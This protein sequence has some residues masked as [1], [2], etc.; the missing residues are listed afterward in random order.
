M[1]FLANE[2]FPWPSVILLREHNIE[3]ISIAEKFQEISDQEVMSIAI[4]QNLTI[5]THD[6]DY[7]ELIFR[8]G[9]KP[10]SGVIFFRIHEFEPKDPAKILLDLIDKKLSFSRSLTVIDKNSIRQRSY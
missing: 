10:D 6:S 7:G 1:A 9:L 3:V 4:N 8:Y 2:N 5:L